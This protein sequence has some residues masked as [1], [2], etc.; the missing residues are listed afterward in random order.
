[1]Q[2]LI[3]AARAYFNALDVVWNGR[4][5]R[6]G[7]FPTL[8]EMLTLE[9]ALKEAE[10]IEAYLDGHTHRPQ[11]SLTESQRRLGL[12]SCR[13]IDQPEWNSDWD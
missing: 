4:D 7:A 11:K 1:M 3:E 8:S 13:F 10:A 6:T 12:R 2:R 5:W 9:T